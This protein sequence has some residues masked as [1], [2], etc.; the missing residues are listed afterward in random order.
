MKQHVIKVCQTAYYDSYELKRISSIHRY[1]TKAAAKQLATSCIL[2]RLDYCNSLLMGT[3]NPVSNSTDAESPKY[4]CTPHSQSTT[5]P[6]LHTTPTATPLAP[7]FWTNKIQNCW[8]VLQR[9]HRFCSLLSFWTIPL[10]S[11]PLSPLFVRHT[12]AQTPVLQQQSP[13]LSHFFT[14]WPPHLEQSLPRRPGTLLLSHHSK[15]NSRHFS[16]Q[17]I[18]DKQHCPSSLSVCTVCVC[19]C[20]GG[21]GGGGIFC[22][23][24][25]EPLS[26]LCVKTVSF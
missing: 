9:N 1:L 7:N 26:T 19:V 18:S 20:G 12:H 4:C 3:P 2:S 23:V 16:S 6:K 10:Q 5:P 15:A 25:L 22:I 24:M 11:F 17:N 14:L 13:W 21:G 8:H